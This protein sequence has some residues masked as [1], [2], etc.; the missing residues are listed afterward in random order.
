M[1]LKFTYGSTTSNNG[2]EI[3]VEGNTTIDF[4]LTQDGIEIKNVVK[5]T[6]NPINPVNETKTGMPWWGILLIAIASAGV[7]FV[8]R[9][10]TFKNEEQ[11]DDSVPQIFM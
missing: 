9:H 10:F 5:F 3:I 4:K 7:G 1:P 6:N 8:L 2:E 11:L